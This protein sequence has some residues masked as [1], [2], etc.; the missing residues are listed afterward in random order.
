M[1]RVE[2]FFLFGLK[3][4]PPELDFF[5]GFKVTFGITFAWEFFLQKMVFS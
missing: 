3:L 5:P 2:S 1:S 4:Y